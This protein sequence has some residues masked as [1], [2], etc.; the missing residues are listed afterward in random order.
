MFPLL[1]RP[2]D[3]G[4]RRRPTRDSRAAINFLSPAGRPVRVLGGSPLASARGHSQ[5]AMLTNLSS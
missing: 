2:M 1:G 5:P 4:R 3:L